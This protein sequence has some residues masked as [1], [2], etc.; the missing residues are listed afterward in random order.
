MIPH[1]LMH[2]QIDC[3]TVTV[4]YLLITFK[5]TFTNVKFLR[6]LFER[7]LAILSSLNQEVKRKVRKHTKIQQKFCHVGAKSSVKNPIT[8]RR[9]GNL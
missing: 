1:F 3:G 9:S 5:S 7:A 8:C 6:K 2:T 4:P